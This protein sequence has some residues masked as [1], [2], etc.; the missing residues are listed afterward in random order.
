MTNEDQDYNEDVK[1]N[2]YRNA[3][4][5]DH[6]SNVWAEAAKRGVDPEPVTGKKTFTG[7]PQ[8]KIEIN[9]KEK[10]K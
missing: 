2:R 5:M 10:V 7:K 4:S 8:E 1:M 6:T 9:P 3:I